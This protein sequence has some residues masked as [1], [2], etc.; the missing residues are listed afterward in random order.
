MNSLPKNV[1][2]TSI[3]LTALVAVASVADFLTGGW[4]FATHSMA[5]YVMDALFVVGA[6]IV[7]YLAIDALAEQK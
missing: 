7:I 6:G 3:G 4:V 1:L 2:Y 5:G